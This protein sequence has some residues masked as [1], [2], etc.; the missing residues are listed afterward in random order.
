M[1]FNRVILMGNLVENPE[2]KY[3]GNS[4]PVTSFRL[5]VA[6]RFKSEEADTDF[7]TIV[8]WRATAE[9]I[10]KHFEKGKPILVSGSLQTRS[11]TDNEGNKRSVVEVMADEVTFCGRKG[12]GT[13]ATEAVSNTPAPVSAP[14]PAYD[15]DLPF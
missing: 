12:E 9:F 5:A 3:T 10:C 15:D 8:A 13:E 7:F 2:L 1:A 4:I 6:R 11:W 14:A